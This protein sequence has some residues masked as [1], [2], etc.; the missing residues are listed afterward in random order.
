MTSLLAAEQTIAAKGEG[1]GPTE[2]GQTAQQRA[3]VLRCGQHQRGHEL[4][5]QL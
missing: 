4:A 2:G 3:V 1:E 5:D